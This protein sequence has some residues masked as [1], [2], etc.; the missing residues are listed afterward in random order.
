MANPNLS[1]ADA[2]RVDIR[3]EVSTALALV[4]SG[5]KQVMSGQQ[6]MAHAV[7]RFAD[8]G[9]FYVPSDDKTQP[10]PVSLSTL[11]DMFIRLHN[12]EKMN[13]RGADTS[14]L[15]D[16]DKANLYARGIAN[17]FFP[18]PEKPKGKNEAHSL[19]Y[20]KA[21]ENATKKQATMRLAINLAGA[22]LVCLNEKYTA[23]WQE[24]SRCFRVPARA[25]L[26]KGCSFIGDTH[27]KATLLLDNNSNST[28]FC[29][30]RN[31]KTG[32]Q[33]FPPV[34]ASVAQLLSAQTLPKVQGE[35]DTDALTLSKVSSFI[36]R[37]T[38]DTY[39]SGDLKLIQNMQARLTKIM[40]VNEDGMK[41][42]AEKKARKP[43]TPRTPKSAHGPDASA[44]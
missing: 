21:R 38:L 17:Y 28:F 33:S 15:L 32:K 6:M 29:L 11:R 20:K 23:A 43:R 16:K 8:T 42:L 12:V 40:S 7:L 10:M 37:L 1:N 35:N 36:L 39:S 41:A 19:D 34:R 4:V 22:L 14:E 27:D 5:T 13:K 25:L 3:R 9:L 30:Y 31:P 18:M 44:A 24:K 26:P 2:I